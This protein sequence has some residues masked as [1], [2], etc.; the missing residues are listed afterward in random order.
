M[1]RP[2]STARRS[3][4]KA[5]SATRTA[6]PRSAC[7]RNTSASARPAFPRPYRR[8]PTSAGTT[9]VEAM[10]GDI[11]VNAHRESD[12]PAQG[13]AVHLAFKPDR[14]ASIA[15]AG[16]PLRGLRHEG[17]ENQAPGLF[18][19]PVVILVAFNALIPMMTVVNYSVQETFGNNVFFWEGPRLVRTA[20]A[21]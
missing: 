16:S 2:F 3:I 12:P 17:P 14:R 8:S 4:W 21:L 6:W 15:T 19:L 11:R 20:D 5:Q 13:E 1:G 18:V 9:V 10:V 7:A